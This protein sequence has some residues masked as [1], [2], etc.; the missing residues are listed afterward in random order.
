[1]DNEKYVEPDDAEM[2]EEAEINAEKVREQNETLLDEFEKWLLAKGLSENT[3]NKHVNNISFYINEYLLYYYEIKPENGIYEMG[4]FLGNWFIRKAMWSSVSHIKAYA[5]GFKKFYKFMCEKGSI[6]AEDYEMVLCEI[7]EGL[8]AW[9][10]AMED[11]MS[12]DFDFDDW[13][14]MTSR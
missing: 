2:E 8:P 11:Y 4:G 5:G 7:K 14:Y 13:L 6:S 9:I 1:V 10:K 3:V 12:P